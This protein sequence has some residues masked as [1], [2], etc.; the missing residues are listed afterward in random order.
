M[1]AARRPETFVV[2]AEVEL[3]HTQRRV[4]QPGVIRRREPVEEGVT[5]HRAEGWNPRWLRHAE[6]VHVVN[7]AGDDYLVWDENVEPALPKQ[8]WRAKLRTRRQGRAEPH[9]VDEAQGWREEETVAAAISSA[10]KQRRARNGG[11][12]VAEDAEALAESHRRTDA[13]L[14]VRAPPAAPRPT[15]RA[16]HRSGARR[17]SRAPAAAATCSIGPWRPPPSK[18]TP[19]SSPPTRASSPRRCSPSPT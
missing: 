1:A 13:L 11:E 14:Q 4:W 19:G 12:A 17:T 3:Y 2:G 9:T 6:T 15:G 18:P 8:F 16:E 5:W 7:E 10:A